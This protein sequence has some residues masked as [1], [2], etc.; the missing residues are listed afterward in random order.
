MTTQ[1][2]L[3]WQQI[4]EAMLRTALQL[5]YMWPQEKMKRK[6]IV[7][8]ARGGYVPAVLLS[9]FLR[10]PIKYTI[11]AHSYN[12]QN[13]Q[14]ATVKL[15]VKPKLNLEEINDSIFVD[16]IIDTGHTIK[17]I[18]AAFPNARF[19]AAVGKPRGIEQHCEKLLITPIQ[20][21]SNDTWVVFPWE[22][23][24]V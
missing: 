24:H 19:V 3:T 16:D 8:I 7:S 4:E 21:V 14:E 9:N 10:I 6:Y 13:K 1:T 12:D 18:E 20:V 11:H 22:V 5:K 17:A 2:H 15:H 23:K